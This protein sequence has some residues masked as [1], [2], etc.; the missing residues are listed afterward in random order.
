MKVSEKTWT[1]A[2]N[3]LRQARAAINQDLYGM[4]PG[5]IDRHPILKNHRKTEGKIT[6]FLKRHDE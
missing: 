3:L 5:E 6:D 2:M 1:E 4:E